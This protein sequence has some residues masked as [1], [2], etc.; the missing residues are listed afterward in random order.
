MRS[1]IQIGGKQLRITGRVVRIGRLEAEGYQFVD[2]PAPLLEE[3]RRSRTRVD[4]FTFMQRLPKTSPEFSYPMEWDNFAALPVSTFD[5]WWN[6]QI[7]FKARN[8]A[9]QA[10]KKGV[11]LREVQF[12]DSLAQGIVDIYN[13]SPVRQGRAFFNYGKTLETV[14]RQAS[15]F[16][17]S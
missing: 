17:E 1:L 4:L 7:G 12:D 9:K 14:R 15:T 16:L 8:K 13:E 5:H 2:D 10:E 3:L 6:E 11:I